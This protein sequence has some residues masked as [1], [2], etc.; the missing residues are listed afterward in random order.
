MARISGEL[1]KA[2]RQPDVVA[3]LAKEANTVV[4]STPQ[5]FQRQINSEVER[6]K[7]LVQKTGF[8]FEDN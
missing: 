1:G 6:W 7:A 5:E 4:A 8:K 2:A 3:H